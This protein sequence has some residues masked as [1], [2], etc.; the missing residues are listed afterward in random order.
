MENSKCEKS[1]WLLWIGRWWHWIAGIVALITIAIVFSNRILL[2]Q[3]DAPI[4]HEI[5]GTYGDFI[6]G[7][8]S[9]ISVFLLVDTIREQRD[10]IREQR[11]A[12]EEQRRLSSESQFNDIFFGLLR[13]LQKEVEDLNITDGDV[14]A[15]NKDYF[16]VLRKQMQSAYEPTTSY[17]KNIEYGIT[18]YLQVY[19]QNPRLSSY[20]RLLYRICDLTHNADLMPPRKAEYI[21]ILRAQLTPSE[22]FLLRY[23]AQTYDGDKFKL[24]ICQ[25]NLLKH[26]PVFELLEFKD[27]W[28]NMEETERY[29]VSV[30]ADRLRR[31][32]KEFLEKRLESGRVKITPNE[33]W[34]LELK[35]EDMK[36]FV[37]LMRAKQ[38]QSNQ[39]D[40]FDDMPPEKLQRLLQCLLLEIFSYSTF[41]TH[42]KKSDL[43]IESYEKPTKNA[44]ACFVKTKDGLPL[45][46]PSL[47]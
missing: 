46:L 28:G 16:E 12:I 20:F 37:Y 17:K 11:D 44:I 2:W 33:I 18:V 31:Y 1:P 38:Q 27:W 22:L 40:I 41:E 21:R 14:T 29:R 3:W 6:G 36:V 24:Y 10:A 7:I 8:L 23:N 39:K 43:G 32:M 47:D 25:Y 26:L 9:A 4:A 5:W 42:R 30:F 15:T 34:W 45:S 19:A 13:H 35:R